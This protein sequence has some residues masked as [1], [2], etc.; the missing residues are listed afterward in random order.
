[1][2]RVQPGELSFSDS[3]NERNRRYSADV[4]STNSLR[5]AVAVVAIGASAA[6]AGS[7]GAAVGKPLY[8]KPGKVQL[9][10]IT[11]ARAATPTDKPTITVPGHIIYRSAAKAARRDRQRICTTMKVLTPAIAPA[12]GWVVTAKA[13]AL[14][15]WVP[16]GKAQGLGNWVWQGAPGV[17]YHVQYDVTWATKK[18][19]KLAA[20]TYDF[21]TLEDYD[22]TTVACLVDQGADSIPY[23]SFFNR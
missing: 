1:L 17:E 13:K 20:A 21:N 18:R 9:V 19:K 5:A 7:V 4:R 12:T 16:V 14:C 3:A 15:G 6:L 22:C 23:I 10:K 2:V 8:G 11:G